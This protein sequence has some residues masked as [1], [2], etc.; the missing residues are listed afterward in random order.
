MNTLT[1]KGYARIY[2]EKPENVRAVA[3]IIKEMDEFEHSYMPDDMV[4]PFSEYPKLTY[5]HKF[6]ALDMNALAATCW[7]RGIHI[8]VCDNGHE[9]YM[10]DARKAR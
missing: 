2:V 10:A 4:A 3:D 9:E 7:S 5:T 1:R 6:D 8:F